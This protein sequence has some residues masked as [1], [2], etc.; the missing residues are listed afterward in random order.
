MKQVNIWIEEDIYT[1]LIKE[2]G[3]RMMKTGAEITISRLAA[4]VVIEAMLNSDEN[5][6][7][8]GEKPIELADSVLMD[9]DA[10]QD[11]KQDGKQEL[12]ESAFD[13]SALDD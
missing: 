10:K 8:A 5:L 3:K 13:F 6:P 12:N 9:M 1:L 7:T 11:T 2:A 4:D